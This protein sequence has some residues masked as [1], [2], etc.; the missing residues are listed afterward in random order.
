MMRETGTPHAPDML[1][2]MRSTE[3]QR[4]RSA[5]QRAHN[6]E[7]AFAVPS[8]MRGAVRGQRVLLI[9][10]VLTTGATLNAATVALRDAGAVQVSVAVFARVESATEF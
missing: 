5:V 10:D 4:A 2:R 9:D 1:R 7:G 8:H 3:M 6:V